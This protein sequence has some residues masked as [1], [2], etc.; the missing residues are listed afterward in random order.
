MKTYVEPTQ[1]QLATIPDDHVETDENAR[2]TK[3]PVN[4]PYGNYDSM[5]GAWRQ[6]YARLPLTFDPELEPGWFKAWHHGRADSIVKCAAAR[7][8]IRE[9]AR[10]ATLVAPPYTP[11]RTPEAA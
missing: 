9:A 3:A 4:T 10:L 2:W 7:A 6:G 5:A 8:A 1:D 11:K